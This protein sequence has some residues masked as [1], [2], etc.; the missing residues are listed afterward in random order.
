MPIFNKFVFGHRFLVINDHKQNYYSI[1][2][3]ARY[4]QWSSETVNNKYNLLQEDEWICWDELNVLIN[5]LTLDSEANRRFGYDDYDG[6]LYFV[7][8]NG[9][10]KLMVDG[11][12]DTITILM[13]DICFFDDV[14]LLKKP[15][16]TFVVAVHLDGTIWTDVGS[17]SSN[18]NLYD[19]RPWKQLC[20]LKTSH[21]Y[22]DRIWLSFNKTCEHLNDPTLRQELH[23]IDCYA[24]IINTINLNLIEELLENCLQLTGKEQV[25]MLKKVHLT[26]SRVK[27]YCYYKK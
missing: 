4:M 5:R 26:V 13:S 12:D 17:V 11:A 19:V 1:N 9:L 15:V 20:K 25:T 16:Q 27:N 8:S 24:R 14:V 23:M 10:Q 6:D 22:N 21:P 2:D 7:T 3:V 18:Y